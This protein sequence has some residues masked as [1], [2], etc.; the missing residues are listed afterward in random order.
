MQISM[1]L[2]DVSMPQLQLMMMI[3]VAAAVVDVVDVV[4]VVEVVV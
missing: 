3:E 2:S 1:P 4:D